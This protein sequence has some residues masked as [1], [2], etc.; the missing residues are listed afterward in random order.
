M[1]R[2]ELDFTHLFE[3]LHE[4]LRSQPSLWSSAQSLARTFPPRLLVYAKK[5]LEKNLQLTHEEFIILVSHL[6]YHQA[7][8]LLHDEDHCCESGNTEPLYTWG[9]IEGQIEGQPKLSNLAQKDHSVS[10]NP[11]QEL[12]TEVGHEHSLIPHGV[13][14][15]TILALNLQAG[16]KILG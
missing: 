2:K 3:N 15:G 9:Q 7:F 8:T 1:T 6:D 4:V 14:G 16:L 12:Y 5:E 10:S 13:L 11:V